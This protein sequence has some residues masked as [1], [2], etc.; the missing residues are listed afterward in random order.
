MDLDDTI[1]ETMFEA[2]WNP[3]EKLKNSPNEMVN[4]VTSV[5][6]MFL[7]ISEMILRDYREREAGTPLIRQLKK[8]TRV[9]R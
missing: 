8:S 5:I 1:V 9:G 2:S 3:L 6:H 7:M 4:S